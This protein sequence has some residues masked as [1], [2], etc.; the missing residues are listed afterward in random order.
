MVKEITV[1]IES[2]VDDA[3][4]EIIDKY[5]DEA[6]E[7][8]SGALGRWQVFIAT[9]TIQL[10]EI[11]EQISDE[12]VKEEYLERFDDVPIDAPRDFIAAISYLSDGDKHMARTM[13]H[14]TFQG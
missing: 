3:L 12:D 5:G 10:G 6:E 7:K 13:F 14:R 1:E 4:D 11:W 8:L 9:G 2:S